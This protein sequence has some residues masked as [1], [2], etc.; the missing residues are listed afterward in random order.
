[1]T[2]N[3]IP[4]TTISV[5]T[6]ARDWVNA[7]AE[8]LG[9]PQRQVITLLIEECDISR[10]KAKGES[11]EAKIDSLHDSLREVLR[12]DER[13]IAFIREQER[14]ILS[15]ILNTS[16]SIDARVNELINLLKDI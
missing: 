14:S 5:D 6:K 12:R 13:I 4:T 3:K 11:P 9:I 16:I 1:M 7:E 15:P 10:K 8:R 2:K